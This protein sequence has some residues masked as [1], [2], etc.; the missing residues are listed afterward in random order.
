MYVWVLNY[1]GT[2]DVYKPEGGNFAS[3]V[4]IK[5]KLLI[6]GDNSLFDM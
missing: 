2:K 6:L 4:D 3:S 1:Y 5:G